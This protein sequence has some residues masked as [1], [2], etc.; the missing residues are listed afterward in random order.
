MHLLNEC[1]HT[2]FQIAATQ[3][4][5]TIYNGPFTHLLLFAIIEFFYA[6]SHLPTSL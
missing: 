4:A 1:T 6:Y 5:E 2:A 3:D